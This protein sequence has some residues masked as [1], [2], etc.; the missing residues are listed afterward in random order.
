MEETVN[1]MDT[2]PFSGLGLKPVTLSDKATLSA[3]FNQLSEPLS[4]YT[5][6]QL[7]TWS[8]ALRIFWR[9]LDGHLCVFANGSGDLTML[10]PPLGD[11]N[12]GRALASAYEIMDAYNAP[13]GT[14][15]HGR[16][17]YASEE[18]LRR[19]DPHQI[20]ASPLAVDYVYDT[21][22]MIELTGGDLAS[23]RQAKNRFM[24][25]YAYSVQEYDRPRHVELCRNLL[26]CWKQY[27]DHQHEMEG[28]TNATKRAK[29][30]L[31]SEAA[32]EY[33]PELG[34]KGLVVYVRDHGPT[35][36]Q[37]LEGDGWAVRGF[38]FG[39]LL[40]PKQASIVIEKTDLQVK[41]LAQFIFSEFCGRFWS[42]RA[43]INVGDDWGLETLAWTKMSY[44]PLRLMQKATFRRKQVVRVAVPTVSFVAPLVVPAASCADSVVVSTTHR[45]DPV[46]VKPM[47]EMAQT[48]MTANVLASHV[49]AEDGLVMPDAV[50]RRAMA[51]DLPAA[52]S[53]EARCFH[54]YN[55][56]KRQLRY[57]QKRSSAVFFVAE[58]CGQVVGEGISL[59][60]R[61]KHGYSGRIYSLGVDPQSRGRHIGGRLLRAMIG[62]LLARGA[63]RIYLEVEST[64]EVACQLY[65]RNGF[66]RIGTLKDYYGAGRD[67]VHMVYEAS[68]VPPSTEA[69]SS[70]NAGA[71]VGLTG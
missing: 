8:R 33:A 6:S 13:L 57:L 29:E 21:R 4:D 32:L 11:G 65:E 67:G 1:R 17:E 62:E 34:F 15:D 2:S 27:Q 23:K 46:V 16:V 58:D 64:N 60:R 47:S 36:E 3:Y 28:S 56:S 54:S 38:T 35:G 31:A 49:P 24:R 26:R 37:P 19:F 44:R 53:L 39:E 50:V 5:F 70:S 66:R 30:S 12:A 18:L 43:E 61:H 25:N 52:V 69:P 55:L 10:L 40:G 45:V 14:V 71:Q 68:G 51:S 22:H 42:Q 41:G 59:I 48:S 9:T 20:D 63:R 7:F